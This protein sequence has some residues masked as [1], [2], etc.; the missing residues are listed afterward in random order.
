[1]SRI[2]ILKV[3]LSSLFLEFS[4]ILSSSCLA[5]SLQRGKGF[6]P[7]DRGGEAMGFRH[8]FEQQD[9]KIYLS[10]SL[11]TYSFFVR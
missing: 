7:K 4:L 3:S 11:A 2:T 9:R 5:C 6:R 8:S 10:I 1:M